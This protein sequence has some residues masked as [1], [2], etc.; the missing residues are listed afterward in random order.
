LKK[1]NAMQLTPYLFFNGKCEEAIEFY[2][3]TLGATVEMMMRFS[4][5]PDKPNPECMPADTSKIM[6]ASWRVGDAVMMGSDGMTSGPTDFKG[7]SLALSV[8]SEAEARTKFEALAKGGQVHQP[9]V[10]TFFSPAFGMLQDKFGVGWMV[11]ATA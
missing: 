4:D 2:K 10:K 7:F 1:E 11:M 9:L 8:G 5:N 3:G 6:H